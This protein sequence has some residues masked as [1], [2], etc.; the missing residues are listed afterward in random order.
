VRNP[1]RPGYVHSEL[2]TSAPEF[3]ASSTVGQNPYTG[4]LRGI[5]KRGTDPDFEMIDLRGRKSG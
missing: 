1:N 4:L 3:V 5:R 2:R